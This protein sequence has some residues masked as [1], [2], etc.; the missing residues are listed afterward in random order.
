MAPNRLLIAQ[1]HANALS[2][3]AALCVG[4]PPQVE[5][6]FK[7]NLSRVSCVGGRHRGITHLVPQPHLLPERAW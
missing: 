3:H 1:R 6:L 5:G 7:P 2:L 4:Q